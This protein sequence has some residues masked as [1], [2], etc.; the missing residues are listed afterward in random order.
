MEKSISSGERAKRDD[1]ISVVIPAHNEESLI[2]ECLHSL[3][4]GSV[5]GELEVIVACNGC[6]D[7]TANAARECGDAVRVVETADASK[8]L[9][10]NLGDSHATGFP[11][12]Y[13]D[14]DVAIRMEAIRAVAEVLVNEEALAAAPRMDVQLQGASWMVRAFYAVWRKLPY[15]RSGMIGSGV[16]ALS[17]EGRGRFE[18]FPNIISDDGYV[19]ALFE[20]GERLTLESHSFEIRAPRTIYDLMKIKTRSRLGRYEL[21]AKYPGLDDSAHVG[22]WRA[23]RELALS[24][25]LWLCI[26]VY[27]A[28]VIITI[29]R[30][31]QQFRALGQYVWERDESTRTC[32]QRGRPGS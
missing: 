10:L 28:V 31:K 11:R 9:A 13:I 22:W 5:S 15:H 14:A 26:P 1:M 27:Y 19:R 4:E 7:S 2:S 24:P 6:T 18:E 25:R 12:F 20:P 17:E 8:V 21:R 16:Y 32:S 29:C 3:L 30:S 23:L